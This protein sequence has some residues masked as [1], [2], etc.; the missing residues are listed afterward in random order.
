MR[1]RGV[2][3]R[4]PGAVRCGSGN[5]LQ[6][7]KGQSPATARHSAAGT[8]RA[9]GFQRQQ[10]AAPRPAKSERQAK[11]Q[12]GRAG[13]QAGANARLSR[14]TRETSDPIQAKLLKAWA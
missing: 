12:A 2:K 9:G 7:A 13:E 3:C 1:P 5:T 14:A 8:S 10:T 11:L 4:L 6:P